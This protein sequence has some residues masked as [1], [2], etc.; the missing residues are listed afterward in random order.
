MMKHITFFFLI[1]YIFFHFSTSIGATISTFYI[2]NFIIKNN[3]L[4]IPK[5][6][7]MAYILID[8]HSGKVLTEMNAD[9]RYNPASLTKMMT[10]Y[11]IG[12][13]LK[14]NN[15][16]SKD[17]VKISNN[18]WAT[19]NII[20]KGSSLMFIKPGDYVSVS[21]L[22]RGINL[23]SGNDACVAMAEY[24][25][26][27]QNV[28]VNLMN[29]YVKKFHLHNTYFKTVHGL[30]QP[31]QYTSARDMARIA[32]LLIHD[33]PNEYSIYKEKVFTFNNI[34]QINRNS[35]LWDKKLNVD[36]IK[37]G[38]TNSSGYHI[39]TSATKGK[40]RLICVVL[41][42]HTNKGREIASKK[43][44]TWGFHVF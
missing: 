8:Y 35:L 34:R 4:S 6:D 5:I 43:L 32:Q 13:A 3:F 39:V 44:L 1:F 24:I 9:K 40:T 14:K 26:G 17:V 25:S 30:D 29:D 22:N 21:M 16:T 19:G 31:G 7:A 41:G 37:T 42:S 20:F 12:Q 27:S 2:N 33:V 11:I 38:H 15:I 28:F 18:A 10:S 36:G 23:Q